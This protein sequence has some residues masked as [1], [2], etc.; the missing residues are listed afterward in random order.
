MG[1]EHKI[2]DIKKKGVLKGKKVARKRLLQIFTSREGVVLGPNVM[3]KE[4]SLGGPHTT[5]RVP[6]KKRWG[7]NTEEMGG[8]GVDN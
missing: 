5:H 4:Y 1:V 2:K 8:G 6:G 7:N 3:G